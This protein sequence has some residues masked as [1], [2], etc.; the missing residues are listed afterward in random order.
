MLAFHPDDRISV[1]DALEHPY[2]K[3]FHASMS[4]PICPRV[5]DF[6]FE[7]RGFGSPGG[8]NSMNC[9]SSSSSSSSVVSETGG[10]TADEVRFLMFEEM[11][12]FR[13]YIPAMRMR[14]SGSDS[15][16]AE[17]RFLVEL[18]YILWIQKFFFHY[19]CFFDF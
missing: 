19:F 11:R 18:N 1:Q 10:L 13:N 2:L 3:D 17:V 4:E 8:G 14:S 15:K 9:G 6:D 12:K 7:R 16:D 5:F